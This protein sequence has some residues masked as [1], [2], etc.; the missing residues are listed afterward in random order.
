[1]IFDL[2]TRSIAGGRSRVQSRQGAVREQRHFI[3][4]G[5]ECIAFIRDWSSFI[6]EWSAENGGI[7][8]RT[9]QGPRRLMEGDRG[10]GTGGTFYTSFTSS[11]LHFPSSARNNSTCRLDSKTQRT[12]VLKIPPGD[13]KD[14]I[15]FFAAGAAGGAV[16]S[17][18]SLRVTV[19]VVRWGTTVALQLRSIHNERLTVMMLPCSA[20]APHDPLLNMI[21]LVVSVPP[22]Y[23]LSRLYLRHAS[24]A[25]Y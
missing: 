20:C 1:M 17:H 8:V 5:G 9:R 6:L 19:C 14:D 15:T 10:R 11:E 7:A 2:S 25:G 16:S 12:P 4:V 21:G 22:G 3:L 13:R 18:R 23:S 24:I